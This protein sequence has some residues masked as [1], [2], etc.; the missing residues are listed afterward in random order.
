[1]V[2]DGLEAT[3]TEERAGKH[4]TPL[5]EVRAGKH[6]T[7]LPSVSGLWSHVSG[8]WV[9]STGCLA[10]LLPATPAGLVLPHRAGI[11]CDGPAG[12]T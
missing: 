4:L 11:W 1:M 12:V 5:P 7:P 6:L 9:S 3:D 10:L 2:H 8:D